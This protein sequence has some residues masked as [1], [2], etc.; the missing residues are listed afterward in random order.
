MKK[1]LLAIGAITLGASLLGLA[2]PPAHADELPVDQPAIDTAAISELTADAGIDTE[3]SFDEVAAQSDYRHIGSLGAVMYGAPRLAAEV[4][5]PLDRG[6]RVVA[7][8]GSNNSDGGWVKIKKNELSNPITGY[9][10]AR[11]VDGGLEGLPTT[12]PTEAPTVDIISYSTARDG[13]SVGRWT[14]PAERPYLVSGKQ[15]PADIV[16]GL[17]ISTTGPVVVTVGLPVP[18]DGPGGTQYVAGY[19]GGTAFGFQPYSAAVTATCT[20]SLSLAAKY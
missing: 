14:C 8:C 6:E 19:T 9:V 5:A 20:N 13:D 16:P 18:I 2:A 1:S 10:P 17:K 12:C 15:N 11:F 4:L 7:Y 3:P